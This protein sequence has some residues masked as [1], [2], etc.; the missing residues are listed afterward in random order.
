[1][2]LSHA[3]LDHVP[4]YDEIFPT[5]NVQQLMGNTTFLMKRVE[6]SS[7]YQKTFK[8]FLLWLK[9]LKALTQ[10]VILHVMFRYWLRVFLIRVDIS[11]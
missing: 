10:Y 6:I 9:L 7:S 11:E 8:S 2:D 1:M 5:H 3:F 4:D